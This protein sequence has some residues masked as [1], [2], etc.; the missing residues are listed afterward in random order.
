[1]VSVR[2]GRAGSAFSGM[3][4]FGSRNTATSGEI[5]GEYAGNRLSIGTSTGTVVTKTDLDVKE[6]FASI[7]RTAW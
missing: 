1:M 4:L 2:S 7:N 6:R 3:G 5:Y